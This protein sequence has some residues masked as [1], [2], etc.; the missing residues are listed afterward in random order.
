MLMDSAT[1]W[2]Q[3]ARCGAHLTPSGLCA[4]SRLPPLDC[5]LS[6]HAGGLIVPEVADTPRRPWEDRGKE[7]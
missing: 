7:T 2:P 6:W 1:W 4:W 3:C 5:P